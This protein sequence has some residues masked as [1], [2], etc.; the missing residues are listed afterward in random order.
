MIIK[1]AWTIKQ[2]E[3]SGLGSRSKLYNE[4]KAGRLISHK[5]G[6]RRIVTEE[7]RAK[8]LASLPVAV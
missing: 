7:N 3:Q 1:H 4:M 2:L 6:K 5:Q 8:Y